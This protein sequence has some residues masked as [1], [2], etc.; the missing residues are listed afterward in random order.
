MDAPV[1]IFSLRSGRRLAYLDSRTPAGAPVLFLH[2]L[3]SCR[4]MRPDAEV[5][6]AIGARLITFDR[7]ALGQSDANPG[8]SLVDTAD[9][10]VALLDHLGL[11]KVYVAAPSGGGPPALA[12][13]YR[14]PDRIHA[15]AIPR[16][17]CGCV[18]AR[19][20]RAECYRQVKAGRWLPASVR[21][22]V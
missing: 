12:F 17:T 6:A 8:R 5:T 18:C 21:A 15:V 4:L 19:S 11:D 22:R 3:R 13:A 10:V 16:W 20:P 1:A 9:D 2:G 7:P 14:A